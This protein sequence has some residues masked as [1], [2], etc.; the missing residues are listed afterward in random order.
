MSE[1]FKGYQIESYKVLTILSV[2][3]SVVA[4]G[5]I[6]RINIKIAHHYLNAGG[7]TQMLFGI[8]ELL[9]YSY[10]YYYLVIGLAS[11]GM[12][13]LAR[14]KGKNRKYFRIS[15]ALAVLSIIIIFIP[16]WRFVVHIYH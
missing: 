14:I 16:L 4:I 2:I 13:W 6:I 3:C 15:I 10:K 12:A 8:V 7:K 9:T 11:I 5:I 1:G